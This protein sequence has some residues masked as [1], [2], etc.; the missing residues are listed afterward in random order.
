M[1]VI[2]GILEEDEVGL[3]ATPNPRTPDKCAFN[4]LVN[5]LNTDSALEVVQYLDNQKADPDAKA[6][7]ER[8]LGKT[9]RRL[10]YHV[11]LRKR[12][13]DD[14]LRSS[15]LSTT[16]DE[17]LGLGSNTTMVVLEDRIKL[18]KEI[19]DNMDLLSAVSVPGDKETY[20]QLRDCLK[21]IN[22]LGMGKVD[23]SRLD[24]NKQKLYDTHDKP[25][26]NRTSFVISR[27]SEIEMTV[28][29]YEYLKSA[30]VSPDDLLVFTRPI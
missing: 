6:L 26:S 27:L 11:S 4:Y 8:Y 16:I 10:T 1:F 13:I 7:V 17:I 24:T 25:L 2:E 3:Y 5:L 20:K 30:N 15:S 22:T 18:F 14:I 28:K 29:A 9:S 23:M 21:D 12:H 19:I